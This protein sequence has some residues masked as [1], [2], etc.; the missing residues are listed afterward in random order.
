MCAVAALPTP[1]AADSGD[2]ALEKLRD[3]HREI[4][5]HAVCGM[6]QKDIAAIVGVTPQT[7][8]NVLRSDVTQAAIAELRGRRDAIIDVSVSMVA[9]K[10]PD[11]AEV[12]SEVMDN[13]HAKPA[14]RVRAALACFEIAGAKVPQKV[15]HQHGLSQEAI[16]LLKKRARS[17]SDNRSYPRRRSTEDEEADEDTIDV[18]AIVTQSP[19]D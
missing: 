5:R 7:V 13:S 1:E 15:N 16:D 17:A 8:S 14:D 2:S 10:L 6:K 11:A 3:S 12:L 9:G 4:I 19:A 18:P